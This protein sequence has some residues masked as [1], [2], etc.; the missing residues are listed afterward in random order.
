MSRYLRAM[1]TISVG[2]IIFSCS[3]KPVKTER[4]ISIIPQPVRLQVQSGEFEIM[5]NTK[6]LFTGNDEIAEIPNFLNEKFQT[7]AG[8]VLEIEKAGDKEI[9]ENTIQMELGNCPDT[10]GVEGYVLKVSKTGIHINANQANGLFYGLQTLRQLL[11]T[12]IESPQKVENMKWTVPVVEITDKPRFP[13]RG[14]LLDCCRHFMEKDFVLRY[15]DLLAYH[16]MNRFHWHLTEDQGWRIEI[17][18]F[19]ALTEIGAWRT[20]EDGS[21]YGGFYTQDEIREVVAY[22]KSRFIE[23]VPEVELP[24]H[25]LAALAAFPEFSCTGGPFEVGNHWGVLKDIFCAGND[26]TF[27]FLEKV[28]YEVF[29]LFPFEYVHVGGDE[30][31]KYRWE[32]CPKC[33]KRIK[34]EGLKDEHELQAYF[35][36][37]MEKYINT[38]GRKLI[39]WD[40]ILEGGLVASA[41]V[42]SWRGFDGAKEAAQQGN[43]AIVSPTSYAYFDY[44][45]ETTDLKQVYSFE[46][47]PAG[48]EEEFQKHIIGGECN[49]WTERAPQE[50]IDDRM[51]PRILAMCEVLWTNKEQRS[52]PDFHA[53]VQDHYK[54]LANL[55][56]KYGFESTAVSVVS[57]YN[58]ESKSYTVQLISGQQGFTIFYTLDGSE[59]TIQSAKYENPININKSTELKVMAARGEDGPTKIIVQKYKIH[60]ATGK[61]VE[62]EFPFSPNYDGTIPNALTD[63]L[64]G[65][66]N[67]RDGKWQGFHGNDLVAVVDLGEAK[68]ISKVTI[69]CLQSQLSWIFMPTA[70]TVLASEDGTTY[71]E[72]ASLS[73]N[74]DQKR[75]DT[76][77]MEFT[78]EFAKTQARFVKVVGKNISKNPTWHDAAG[79][80]S[81]LFADEIAVE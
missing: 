15:I 54:R 76:F 65:T 79:S 74:V 13:W 46:P 50:E 11:P 6:I 53:R 81:W 14:M 58:T 73:P 24:G 67:F 8:F 42:Q 34:D 41:T 78:L 21:R 64:C 37:R 47:I 60:Q 28:Y 57:E 18:Q 61:N 31:P 35:I 19:P 33:Q 1:L 27:E 66:E 38:N 72:L 29:Q 69:G 40:E 45:I 39:G 36:S 48:L 52:Y 26:K 3:E 68:E 71:N 62:L 4:N 49:M 59:P 63:G 77:V 23:V 30:A 9:A 43:D 44:P 32:N 2:L 51:F 70:I 10:L 22:A 20:E 25:A 55:G 80:P 12:E 17:K 16:K 5:P 7:A 56:V 75:S